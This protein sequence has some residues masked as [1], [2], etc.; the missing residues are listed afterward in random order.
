VAE[1]AQAAASAGVQRA[2]R[3]LALF[4]L[5]V[6]AWLSSFA[7]LLRHGIWAQFA[8]AGPA[9][10][11]LA[12]AT[13]A[14]TRALLRPAGRDLGIGLVAGLLMTALTHALFGPI[15]S[16]WPELRGAAEWLLQLAY[17]GAFPDAV[18]AG[19]IVVIAGSEEILF[20]G[21]LLPGLP[22]RDRRVRSDPSSRDLLYI[23]L[24]SAAYA[25]SMITLGSALLVA[26]A[27]VCGLAWATLRV[28]TR[29]LLA[30]IVAHVVW[31]LSVL[32]AWP[33]IAPEG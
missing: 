5:A 33:L 29:S 11:A 7:V 9:L 31:D 19:L 3:Q 4:A 16:L 17:A 10:A 28:A 18:R 26:C 6:A 2:P 25:A 12:L 20:R 15:T 14:R 32:I 13:D 8:I 22:D 24:L 1:R 21:A 30:P 27:F 23:A